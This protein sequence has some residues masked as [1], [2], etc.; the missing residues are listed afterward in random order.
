[1]TERARARGVPAGA[2]YPLAG[3]G[4]RFPFVADDAEGFD[5]GGPADPD[6]AGRFQR[7]THGV[8]Y[9][10]RLAFDVLARLGA[11]VSGPVVATGGGS[12]NDW[13]TQLRADVLQRPV[14]VPEHAGSAIGSAVLAAAPRGELAATAE[15]MVRMRKRFEPDPSRAGELTEG[16]E[17]L[18]E[19]LVE[20]GWLEPGF[21]EFRKAT[22][23]AAQDSKVAFL[24]S[25][26][27]GGSHS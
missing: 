16:Y 9:V 4:E 22:F 27:A 5:V 26:A 18:V 15:A 21:R 20:R 10:E 6:P 17:R 11:D 19:A 24:A 25:D 1:L 7:V 2:T 23:R 3:R 8:A 14:A 13:W 12:R